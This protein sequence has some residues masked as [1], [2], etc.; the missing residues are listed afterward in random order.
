[1]QPHYFTLEEANAALVTIRPLMDETQAIRNRVMTRQPEI[2][3]ALERSAGNGGNPALSRLVGEFQRLDDLVHRI[4]ATGAEIKDLS[5]GLLDFRAW[6]A[7]HEVY[8]CWKHGE[9]EIAYWH[10][11]DSGF[12]GRKPI[13]MY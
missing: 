11:M 5:T 4:L 7:D 6:R 9:S 8:L 1:M 10:E 12:S 13:Q 2:W 3:P